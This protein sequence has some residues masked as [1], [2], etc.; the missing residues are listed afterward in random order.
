ME[1]R[2]FIKAGCLVCTGAV[3]LSTLEACSTL[4]LYKTKT[5]DGLL[6][7]PLTAF[8]D[9]QQVIVRSSDLEFDILLVKNANAYTALYMQCSHETSPLVATKT[10]LYCSMHGSAF[11]LD[12]Q[13]T[14]EPA[15]KPLTKFETIVSNQSIV[16]NPSKKV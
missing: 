4:P 6:T 2:L 13:V 3:A 9:T 8:A 7:V 12:G 10:G 14:K 1:R 15:T 5:Q 16:I 11:S